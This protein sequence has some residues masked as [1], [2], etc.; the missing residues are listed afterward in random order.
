MDLPQSLRIQAHANRLANRRLHAALAS[1]THA[2]F[3]ALR[4]SYFPSFA[5]T[6]N[7]ILAVDLYSVGARHGDANLAAHY[8]AFEVPESIACACPR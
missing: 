6:L 8:G 2:E 4:V 5:A 3:H 7:H 1:L